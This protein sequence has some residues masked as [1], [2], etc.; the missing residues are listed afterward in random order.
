[1]R[2]YN[3]FELEGSVLRARLRPGTFSWFEPLNDRD[4]LPVEI[5]DKT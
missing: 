4:R 5:G 3:G 2:R 1:V